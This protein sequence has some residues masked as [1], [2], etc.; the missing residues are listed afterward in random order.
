MFSK[1]PGT[2]LVLLSC[3]FVVTLSARAQD[4]QPT[5]PDHFVGYLGCSM[6]R[7]A[8]QGY[9][10]LGGTVLWGEIGAY[11][12]GGVSRWADVDN[13]NNRHWQ[14]FSRLLE[15][16][17]QTRFFWIEL[18]SQVDAAEQETY[19]ALLQILE[20]VRSQV[21]FA[22]FFVSAQPA[23]TDGHICH[24]TGADGPAQMQVL[25]DQ[26]VAERRAF[27]G[28]LMGP[29]S[30]EQTSDGCH[31]SREGAE[32]MGQQLLDFF[33]SP[34]FIGERTAFEDALVLPSPES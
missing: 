29:L 31:A 18:C 26:L 24:L 34:L 15:A 27:P 28:P 19:E 10:H 11:G 8:L 21:P 17:P 5:Q 16:H 1:H 6:T 3:L 7:N 33:D 30:A 13:P 14:E 32:L 23:Y 25:V 12:G 2:L 4:P 9:R 22:I 20:H